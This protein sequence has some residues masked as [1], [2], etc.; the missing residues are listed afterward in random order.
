MIK[1]QEIKNS[2]AIQRNGLKRLCLHTTINIQNF[3]ILANSNSLISSVRNNKNR[4]KNKY[5]IRSNLHLTTYLDF[6]SRHHDAYINETI[7][8]VTIFSAWTF[9]ATRR[10]CV[11]VYTI[12]AVNSATS[13]I[14]IGSRKSMCS[15]R[16]IAATQDCIGNNNV[17]RIN[18][19]LY[20]GI[21]R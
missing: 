2:E 14:F 16:T 11:E 5:R 21:V 15:M 6:T 10:E 17:Q 7:V 13:P 18:S 19:V 9:I 4:K 1:A 3:K 12:S 8:P 20:S